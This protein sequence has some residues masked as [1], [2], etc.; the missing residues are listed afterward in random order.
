[1]N[2]AEYI[3][4]NNLKNM[5]KENHKSQRQKSPE[6]KQNKNVRMY[7]KKPYNDNPCK[8]ECSKR[9]KQTEPDFNSIQSNHEGIYRI[10]LGLLSPDDMYNYLLTQRKYHTAEGDFN[11]NRGSGRKLLR[12]CLTRGLKNILNST[13]HPQA[14]DSFVHLTTSGSAVGVHC[15]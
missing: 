2:A 8:R 5:S 11:P 9:N 10:I 4:R 12:K 14:Y 13:L 7:S 3:I 1:M 15:E 6:C